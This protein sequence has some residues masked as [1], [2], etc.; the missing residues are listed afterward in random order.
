[1]GLGFHNMEDFL[2][3]SIVSP[4]RKRVHLVYRSQNS[5]RA[6]KGTSS[7]TQL[8]KSIHLIFYQRREFTTYFV[9]DVKYKDN[10]LRPAKLCRSLSY[11]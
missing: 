6:L 8:R 1:M 11:A 2:C 9:S 4:R 7:T 5:R 10:L 3:Y